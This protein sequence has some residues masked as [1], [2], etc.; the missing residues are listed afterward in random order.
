MAA[1]KQSNTVPDV[2]AFTVMFNTLP[3]ALENTNMRLGPRIGLRFG[4]FVDRFF[5]AING[6]PLEKGQ[7]SA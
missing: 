3:A 1:N 4:F 7:A 6:I 2:T 5:A